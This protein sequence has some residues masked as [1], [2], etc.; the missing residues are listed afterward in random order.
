MSVAVGACNWN[1]Q[2]SSNFSIFGKIPDSRCI[3]AGTRFCSAGIAAAIIQ[4]TVDMNFFAYPTAAERYANGRPFFHP[5]AIKK[6]QAICC[7]RGRI[8][9]ALDVGCG[10]GQSTFALLKVA[11]NIVGVDSS[12]EMLSHAK[13]HARIRFVEARAEQMPFADT[14]FGLITVALAIHWFDQEKFFRESKRLLQRGGWLVIYND[15]FT[16]RM[17]GNDSYEKWN[18]EEYLARY[19]TPPRNSRPMD[20]IDASEY[21]LV[22]SGSDEFNHEVEFTPEQLVGYLVT[23]TN[24]IS[25]VETGKEDLHSVMSWLLNSVRPLFTN[26]KERFSFSCQIRFLKRG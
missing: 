26:A 10:T 1:G 11:D 3:I 24:V 15:G 18:R 22:P 4:W 13:Q 23:Q 17:E 19:P 9:M 2:L 5:L 16:G 8:G 25:A 12:A 6:I 20:E 14:T 21:G 7:E